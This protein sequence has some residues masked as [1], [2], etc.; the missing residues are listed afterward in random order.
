MLSEIVLI[1]CTMLLIRDL[2]GVTALIVALRYT[3]LHRE[4]LPDRELFV[5]KN[6]KMSINTFKTIT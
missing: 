2:S 6:L 3:S 1:H 4:I 5:F